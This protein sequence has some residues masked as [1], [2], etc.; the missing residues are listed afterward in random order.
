MPAKTKD[1][2]TPKYFTVKTPVLNGKVVDDGSGGDSF[3][4]VEETGEWTCYHQAHQRA[5]Q[6]HVN[7]NK[8][9][10]LGLAKGKRPRRDTIG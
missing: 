10:I 5:W 3:E 8:S 4:I 2:K 7:T 9:D 6:T 1:S